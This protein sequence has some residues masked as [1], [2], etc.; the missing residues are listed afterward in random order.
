TT[1][2]RH[3]ATCALCSE[4]EPNRRASLVAVLP[5]ERAV[6]AQRHRALAGTTRLRTAAA[7]PAAH[8]PAGAAPRWA[9]R[10]RRRFGLLGA[11]ARL[12]AA[13]RAGAGAAAAPHAPLV[14]DSA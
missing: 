10:G 7:R 6:C 5:G 9:D 4:M 11:R 13:G 12:A 14:R 3:P 2:C 1:T 8:R